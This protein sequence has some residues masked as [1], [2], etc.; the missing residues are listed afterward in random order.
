M[1]SGPIIIGSKKLK[2]NS[3][4]CAISPTRENGVVY[5]KGI[6]NRKEGSGRTENV[7]SAS[8]R[9]RDADNVSY[10]TE[11]EREGGGEPNRNL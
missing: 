7:E 4:G 1:M 2:M 3:R 8:W 6:G 5:L 9:T 10:C 11:R